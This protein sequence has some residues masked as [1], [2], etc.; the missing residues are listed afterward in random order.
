MADA[1][2]EARQYDVIPRLY[3]LGAGRERDGAPIR[4]AATSENRARELA[5]YQFVEDVNRGGD[6]NIVWRS[7]YV[8]LVGAG[9]TVATLFTIRQA[10]GPDARIEAGASGDRYWIRLCGAKGVL[11]AGAGDT[12]DEA[13]SNLQNAILQKEGAAC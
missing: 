3:D 9:Q 13:V 12:P 2:G 5:Y 7:S 4:I 8:R 10:F 11:A 6:S 1:H